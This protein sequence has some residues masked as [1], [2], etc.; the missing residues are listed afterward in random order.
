MQTSQS[1]VSC[2]EGAQESMEEKNPKYIV[3]KL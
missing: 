1:V 3:H 2:L